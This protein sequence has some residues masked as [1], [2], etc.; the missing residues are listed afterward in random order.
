M[1]S[2]MVMQPCKRKMKKKDLS[3]LHKEDTHWSHDIAEKT[4]SLDTKYINAV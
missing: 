4:S 2:N 1:R 3:L